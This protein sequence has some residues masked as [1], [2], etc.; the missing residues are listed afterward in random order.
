MRR[1][2]RFGE[3]FF[4]AVNG[5]DEMLTQLGACRLVQRAFKQP[6]LRAGNHGRREGIIE[7]AQALHGGISTLVKLPRQRLNDE[8]EIRLGQGVA[9]FVADRVA[10]DATDGGSKQRLR[11]VVEVIHREASHPL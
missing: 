2:R 10:E 3:V 9:H 4:A 5:V 8:G 11:A 7:Q 1:Q 6:R